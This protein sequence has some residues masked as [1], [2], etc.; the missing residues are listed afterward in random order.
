M[1]ELYQSLALKVVCADRKRERKGSLNLNGR[2]IPSDDILFV[3]FV[4]TVVPDK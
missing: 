4:A 3:H 1:N 2:K